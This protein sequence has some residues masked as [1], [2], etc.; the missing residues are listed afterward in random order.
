MA[1]VIK[2]NS[3]IHKVLVTG[4]KFRNI[5]SKNATTKA[6]NKNIK[7]I[8]VPKCGY[9]IP[10]ILT[11]NIKTQIASINNAALQKFKGVILNFMVLYYL[12]LNF[13]PG[14]FVPGTWPPVRLALSASNFLRWFN[15]FF[16]WK[17]PL[18]SG[19]SLRFCI[20]TSLA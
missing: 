4:K 10:V 5:I 20:S 12:F 7:P 2:L 13:L 9:C 18:K 16:S 19:S 8:A 6:N 17:A 14:R 3:T 1:K 15:V 11:P